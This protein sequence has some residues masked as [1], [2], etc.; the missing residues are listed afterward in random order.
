MSRS[1]RLLIFGAIVLI[2][3][4]LV[5]LGIYTRSG[6]EKVAAKSGGPSPALSV[7]IVRPSPIDWPRTVSASGNVAPWQEAIISA[8]IGGEPITN[9]LVDVG[10]HVKKGQLLATF[11]NTSVK[12]A[13]VRFKAQVSQAE[14]NLEDARS[15]ADRATRLRKSNNISDQDLIAA[16]TT[17]KSARAQLQAA[18]AQLASERLML[19][20]TRVVAPDD[21]VISSRSATLGK[22]AGVG[23]EL[24]RLV[25]QDRLEWR[26][27]LTSEQIVLVKPGMKALITL[28]DGGHVVG[29]VRQLSPT[30]NA[31]TRMGIAYVDLPQQNTLARAGMYASGQIVLGDKS[32]FA[33]PASALISRDGRDYVFVL[34]AGNHVSLTTV[35][36]GRRK[37]ADVEILAGLVPESPVI[38]S[39]GA[40]LNDGD[41][42]K[43]VGQGASS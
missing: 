8:Q 40:F 10:D 20:Y 9:V 25:R 28:P 31:D 21:G 12:A 41:L 23:S 42:V 16:Q 32:G 3:V 4:G 26:A 24:F 38:Q 35:T 43:V 27:E 14:A 34:G 37:G 17:E 36:T 19:D 18:Q 5:G 29:K 15:K 11:D 2:V 30:L 1:S 39:G 33:L 22:V 13:L 7:K 6:K